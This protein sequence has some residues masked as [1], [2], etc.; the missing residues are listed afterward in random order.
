LKLLIFNYIEGGGKPFSIGI[1]EAIKNYLI[2]NSTIASNRMVLNKDM[3]DA[4]YGDSIFTR[5]LNNNQSELYKSFPLN[6]IVS[7]SS[8]CKY[9]KISGRF[10]KPFRLTDLCDYCEKANELKVI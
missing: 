7:K 6:N 5:Y 2:E 4:E 9:L 10:K 3:S 8:F 1:R